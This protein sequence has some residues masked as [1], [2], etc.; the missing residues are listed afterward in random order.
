MQR[1]LDYGEGWV[2]TPSHFLDLGS[3]TAVAL[4]LMRYK[5]AGTIRQ[6]A[7]GLY[8]LPR[9]DALIG[10]LAFRR[11]HRAG[12]AGARCHSA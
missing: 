5:R 3:R 9:Q 10:Q 4:A 2:F 12:G 6:I 8:E 7:R 11:C 1:I